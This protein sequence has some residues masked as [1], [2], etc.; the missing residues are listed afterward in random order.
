[1]SARRYKPRDLVTYGDRAYR[2]QVQVA[3]RDGT[4]SLLA[5]FRL[6]AETGR[7]L[8]DSEGG[9]VGDQQILARVAA[10][11]LEPCEYPGAIKFGIPNSDRSE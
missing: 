4:V 5:T 8:P 9:Y 2:W 7:D 6:S 11:E 3:H 1:M 10:S